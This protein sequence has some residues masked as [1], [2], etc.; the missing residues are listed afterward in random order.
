MK[1][2]AKTITIKLGDET[3][4]SCEST[5]LDAEMSVSSTPTLTDEEYYKYLD[6]LYKA[7]RALNR[8]GYGV[9]INMR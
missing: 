4:A 8:A 1:K 9:E 5:C 2:K 7:W 6:M 3:I